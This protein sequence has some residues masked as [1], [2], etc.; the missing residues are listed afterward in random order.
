M[1]V[2]QVRHTKVLGDETYAYSKGVHCKQV[3]SAQ[4]NFMR[5]K[6]AQ[7][8]AQSTADR[9]RPEDSLKEFSE[10][11]LWG[12]QGAET[13]ELLCTVRA[14]LK[15]MKQRVYVGDYVSVSNIDWTSR[16]GISFS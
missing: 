2:A 12:A 13:V 8:T 6:V 7:P 1:Q 15:K 11:T 16:Q 9:E 14:L 3:M 5:I 4:A 10:S